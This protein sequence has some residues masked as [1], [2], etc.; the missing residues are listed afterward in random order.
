MKEDRGTGIR[1]ALAEETS[2]ANIKVMGIGGGGGNALNRMIAMGI[3]GVECIAVNTDL[4]ALSTSRARTKIQIGTKLTKG[5]GSG[6][7]PEVGRQAAEEDKDKLLAALQGADMVFLTA[8]LGGGTGTGATPIIAKLASELDLLLISVVTLPFSFE[9]KYRCR[10][11]DEGLKQLKS[12]ADTVIA[13][14]NDR[15]LQTASEETRSEDAFRMADD[16]LR[17]AVQG[18]TDL[19]T[20]PGLINLDFADV[21]TIMKNMG[22]AYLGTGSAAGH[23]RVVEAAQRAISSPLLCETSI[24][25]SQGMLI[26]V[27]GG[28]DLGLLEVSRAVEIINRLAHPEA[29]VIFGMVIDDSMKDQAKVTVIAT[30]FSGAKKDKAIADIPPRHRKTP[31]PFPIEIEP[32][33]PP[34]ENQ[35]IERA[36]GRV[37]A[38]SAEEPYSRYETPTFIRNKHTRGIRKSI[39]DPS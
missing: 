32:P 25:G 17:Q 19:I 9:L 24:E 23:N 1:F 4:Q 21:R 12:V 31:E 18:V 33:E 20:K 8:G 28:K 26:N 35:E 10:Q 3:E 36:E 22:Q 39:Y 6:G 37:A 27:T 5:L 14:P 11:A 15:L 29:N 13:I 2:V 34:F 7:R 16:V 38:Q 30:G